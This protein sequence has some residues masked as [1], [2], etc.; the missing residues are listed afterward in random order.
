MVESTGCC[1]GAA[2][3]VFLGMAARPLLHLCSQLCLCCSPVRVRFLRMWPVLSF[4][5]R[6][7]HISF[8]WMVHAGCVF[9][10]GIHPSRT[11][12]SGS[13]ESVRWN[14][15][16]HRLD[17]GLY[18]HP[19]ESLKNGVRIHVNSK[20]E[21]PSTRGSEEDRTRDA[22]LHRTVSPTHYRLSY[23]GPL[24]H[25]LWLVWLVAVHRRPLLFSWCVPSQQYAICT[26]GTDP[27]RPLY[28]LPPWD[29]CRLS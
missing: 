10:A 6:G 28:V 9:V 23:S 12:M 3:S 5:H 20:E 21:K 11:W 4:S 22:A 16:V 2:W 25:V 19:K 1:S 24:L 14:T 29:R 27:L 15:C 26:S 13:F 17:L 18:S 8:L 7:S